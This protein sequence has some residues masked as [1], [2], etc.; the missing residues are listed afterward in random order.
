MY[1]NISLSAASSGSCSAPEVRDPHVPLALLPPGELYSDPLAGFPMT[2]QPKVEPKRA[3]FLD[4]HLVEIMLL[5]LNFKPG[6]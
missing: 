3:D 6:G 5:S 4:P 2:R 1:C